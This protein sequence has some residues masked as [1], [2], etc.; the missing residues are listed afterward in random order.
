MQERE[1]IAIYIAGPPILGI[2]YIHAL[3]SDAKGH[4]ALPTASPMLVCVAVD[5]AVDTKERIKI[6]Y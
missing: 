4:L 3:R 6:T 5:R 1:E 2:I